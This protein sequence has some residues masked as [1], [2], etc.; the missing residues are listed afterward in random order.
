MNRCQITF[1]VLALL[2]AVAPAADRDTIY[3]TAPIDALMAGVYDG[4]YPR[5]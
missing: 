3:Q 4:D 1:L 2:A 5:R